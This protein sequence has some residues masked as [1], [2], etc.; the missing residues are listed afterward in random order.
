MVENS[1]NPGPDLYVWPFVAG[2]MATEMAM[3]ATVSFA[4]F[5]QMAAQSAD[6]ALAKYIELAE[7]EMKRAQRKESVRVE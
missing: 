6:T 7:E 1:R 2:K 4:R 3:M 5:V